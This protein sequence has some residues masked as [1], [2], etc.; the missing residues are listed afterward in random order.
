MLSESDLAWLRE[1]FERCREWIQDA[2]DRDMIGTHNIDDIFDGIVSGQAQLW[3]CANAALVTDIE[4]YPRCKI[5]RGW[6]A[7]GKL[8][9]IVAT[10]PVIR[11]WAKA[12]GCNRV[13]IAGRR[14]WVR[15]FDGYHETHTVV[16]RS[17]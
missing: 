5:L 4:E 10:E 9:E 15:V 12:Q 14:G 1:Q 7:G 17:I 3:P 2:L 11:E 16:A 8:E 13:I 6:L